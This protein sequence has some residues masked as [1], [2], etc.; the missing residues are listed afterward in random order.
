MA[1]SLLRRVANSFHRDIVR[2]PKALAQNEG[3]ELVM[4][5]RFAL[6]DYLTQKPAPFFLQ[7]GGFDGVTCDPLHE[8]V[9]RLRLPGIIL[10]PQAWAFARLQQAYADQPQV[11][12]VRAALGPRDGHQTLYKIRD[13]VEAPH[14]LRGLASFDETVILKHR[15]RWP[16]LADAICAE[17]VPTIRFPTLF[18]Q[19]AL[20]PV[21]I[22]QIDTEGFDYEVLKLF[23]VLTRKPPLIHFEHKHLSRSDVNGAL[24]LLIGGG[25]RIA[26]GSVNTVAYLS[27]RE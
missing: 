19:Y 24:A 1:R 12:L 4:E 16:G 10:E 5:F 17:N 21:D 14:A 2:K 9:R 6:A 26:V 8:T 11:M 20:P 23:D 3:C 15:K 22:L 7:V 25:Y 27:N 18:S 13:D